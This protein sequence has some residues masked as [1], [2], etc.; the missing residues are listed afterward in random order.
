MRRK[1]EIPMPKSIPH[2]EKYMT[3]TPHSIGAEQPLENAMKLMTEFSIRHL[4]VMKA[5]SLVGILTDRDVKLALSIRGVNPGATRVD[6]IATEEVYITSPDAPL[7]EV[8]S[9]MAGRKIGSAV[10]VQNHKLVGIFT[11]TD[12]MRVLG[13]I[14][15]TRLQKG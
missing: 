7:D 14:F 11:S 9:K 5:G 10:V 13:E 6:D 3:T 12:A 8:V 4:P 15:H 1:K 2:V